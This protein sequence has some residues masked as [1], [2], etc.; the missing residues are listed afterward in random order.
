MENLYVILKNAIYTQLAQIVLNN[1]FSENEI[2]SAI[3]WVMR[4]IPDIFWFTHQYV[5]TE[6]HR[7]VFFQYVFSPKR[8]KQIQLIIEDVINRDVELN[9]TKELP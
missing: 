8:V 1:F 4:D 9:K 6:S 5:Y 7:T 2:R 3:R